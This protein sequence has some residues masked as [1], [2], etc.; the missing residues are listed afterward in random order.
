VTASFIYDINPA[1]LCTNIPLFICD[2]GQEDGLTGESSDPDDDKAS[3]DDDASETTDGEEAEASESDPDIDAD[4]PV[5]SEMRPES[6][7]TADVPFRHK[8]RPPPGVV[9]RGPIASVY[10]DKVK[11]KK[12]SGPSGPY[13]RSQALAL[14]D[15]LG[16]SPKEQGVKATDAPLPRL[17]SAKQGAR[18]DPAAKKRG[19]KGDA[20]KASTSGIEAVAAPGRAGKAPGERHVDRPLTDAEVRGS[21]KSSCPL[22]IACDLMGVFLT[23]HLDGSLLLL[24]SRRRPEYQNFTLIARLQGG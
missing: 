8:R 18:G 2:S 23:R 11:R 19:K 9:A 22:G 1:C 24:A 17:G 14:G 7:Q 4:H 6:K 16:D 5:G 12:R 15:D 3:V 10:D 13:D 20:Q 21:S